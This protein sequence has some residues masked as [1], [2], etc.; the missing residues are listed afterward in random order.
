MSGQCSHIQKQNQNGV[1]YIQSTIPHTIK[2]VRSTSF[3]TKKIKK[4]KHTSKTHIE[5]R[6][7][8]SVMIEFDFLIVVHIMAYY[9]YLYVYI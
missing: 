4:K 7:N 8:T 5:R 1:I 3:I 6:G 9:L 2:R